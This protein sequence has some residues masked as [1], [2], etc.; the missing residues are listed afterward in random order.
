[1]ANLVTATCSECFLPQLVDLNPRRSEITCPA[2]KHSVPM[3]ERAD[4]EGIKRAMTGERNK[5]YFALGFFAGAVLLFGFYF[6]DNSRD[7]LIVIPMA[8]GSEEKGYLKDR[9]EDYI[10]IK[11][12][13]TKEERRLLYGDAKVLKPQIE[14]LRAKDPIM[15]EEQ[16]IKRAGE[17]H[18]ET[19]RQE[20][21]SVSTPL[22]ILSSLAALGAVALS[23]IATQD[24]LICEF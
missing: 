24:R 9:K 6:F 20:S 7:D 19:E 1:M 3:F 17:L 16:A 15:T 22:L 21:S 13:K 18:V 14:E 12:T 4:M 11:D 10:V 8:D 23:A 5:T 2:C